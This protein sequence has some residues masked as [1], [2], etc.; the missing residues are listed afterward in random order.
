MLLNFRWLVDYLKGT[1]QAEAKPFNQM[2]SNIKRYTAHAIQK[3][4]NMWFSLL[5]RS[6]IQTIITGFFSSIL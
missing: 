2:C 1:L 3:I 6:K 4:L 5:G